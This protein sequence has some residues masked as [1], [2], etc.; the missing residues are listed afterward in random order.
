MVETMGGVLAIGVA[1]AGTDGFADG[2]ALGTGD[3]GKL[4]GIAGITD[5]RGGS[6]DNRPGNGGNCGRG[7]N[8]GRDAGVGAVGKA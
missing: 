5:G 6:V 3:A 2:G 7:G 8:D 1:G 4:I